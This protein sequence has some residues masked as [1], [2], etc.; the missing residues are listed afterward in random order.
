VLQTSCRSHGARTR[1]A[2]QLRAACSDGRFVFVRCRGKVFPPLSGLLFPSRSVGGPVA[3]GVSSRVGAFIGGCSRGG[4]HRP[5]S[6]VG[7]PLTHTGGALVHPVW[8]F[9][10]MHT[11]LAFQCSSFQAL[12]GYVV[13]HR[14]QEGGA[15]VAKGARGGGTGIWMARAWCGGL[16]AGKGGSTRAG[17]PGGDQTWGVR[18][19]EPRWMRVSAAVARRRGCFPGHVRLRG[20]TGRAM[21]G[22]LEGGADRTAVGHLA[23]LPR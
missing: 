18:G 19:G 17:A 20:S 7:N 14:R 9:V 21:E 13:E 10:W 22:C 15:R 12:G 1:S 16:A 2:E 6:V 8:L 3:E 4:T 23:A 11:L 5:V